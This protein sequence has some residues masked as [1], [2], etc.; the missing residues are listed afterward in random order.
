[1]SQDA[2]KNIFIGSFT[3]ILAQKVEKYRPK[4][5]IILVDTHSKF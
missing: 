3:L 1:M 2:P 4:I 5:E